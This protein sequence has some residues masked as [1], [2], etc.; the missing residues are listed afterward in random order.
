LSGISSAPC[1][2]WAHCLAWPSLALCVMPASGQPSLFASAHAGV[3]NSV[4]AAN[5]GVSNGHSL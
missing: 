1:L 3:A 2:D 5:Q 4:D